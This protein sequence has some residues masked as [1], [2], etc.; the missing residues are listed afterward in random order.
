MK[1]PW[2][3]P[4]DDVLR[5]LDVNPEEG[6]SA[7]AVKKR[8]E[9]Y[10]TNRLR[11]AR[12][13]GWLDI[14]WGQI[15][16]LIV[17]LLAVASIVAFA[18]G[19]FIEG[20][21]I[22]VVIVLNT[23]IG[24]FTELRAVKSMEALRELGGVE[25]FVFREGE[26]REMSADDLVPGD[27]VKLQQGDLVTADIRLI[28][29]N[30]LQANE[31]GL[32]GESVAVEKT[33]E[34]VD[35][36]TPLAE[37]ESMVYKGTAITRGEAMGVVVRTGMETE[38]GEITELVDEAESEQTP[39]ERRLETLGNKLIFLTLA[40]ASLVTI[41]GTLAG[42]EL[43]R[44]IETG[45][46]LAV[47]AVPE[48]LPIV[49]TIAL[50]RGM[51]R[52]AEKNA[53]INRLSAVETLGSTTTIFTD[54]T[55]TLTENQM[56]VRSLHSPSSSR[57]R[58]VKE[59]EHLREQEGE[60]GSDLQR[61]LHIGM[62]CNNASRVETEEGTEEMRG[63]PM[64]TALLTAGREMGIR[65][66]E[67]LDRHPEVREEAFSSET[68][69]MATFHERKE[70]N[71]YYVAVKGA[72]E[73]VLE[74]SDRIEVDGEERDLDPSEVEDWLEQN[75]DLASNG[76][77]LLAMADRTADNPEEDPY[78]NLVFRGLIGFLDPPRTDVREAI[79]KAKR[80]GIKVIMVTGDQAETAANIAREVGI[81]TEGHAEV[82]SGADL[83]N[84]DSMSEE[85]KRSLLDI[86]VY[87]RVSPGQKLTLVGLHQ[88]YGGIA[89]MTGDGV[90]DAPAL[91]KA[92]IGISMG[93]R[94]TQ[95]AR[96]ASDM[97]LTDD[98]FSTIVTA[99]EEG[100]IIFENIRKFVFYLLSCN[101]SE[102]FVVGIAS[103][104]SI[105]LPILPLQILFLNLVTDVFPALALGMGEGDKSIMNRPPR[106]PEEP[107]LANRHWWG[108]GLYGIVFTVSVLGAL[109]GASYLLDLPMEEEGTVVTISFL[110]LAFSQLW[111][112]FN[113]REYGSGLISNDITRNTYVWGAIVLCVSLLLAVTYI[114]FLAD[115]LHIQP[116]GLAGWGMIIGMSLLPLIYGQIVKSLEF[117]LPPFLT[118][119]SDRS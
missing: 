68:N 74:A 39:L 87:S 43:Y 81:V 50:A 71:D 112:V 15:K 27:I 19:E 119:W 67:L 51:W 21:A 61:L 91:K 86:P 16:S 101:V 9:K 7:S 47:A 105:P 115:V 33:V 100:R 22:L 6:L 36:D 82:R 3:E 94:G 44:M 60:P 52:M 49:A 102:I 35:E 17:G 1:T 4:A 42:R 65:R 32:T 80:A 18:F 92:D 116:P 85:E 54:K 95:V 89:G 37:R 63:D 11:E 90:N 40:I 57:T 107:V 10:G 46:A 55:G 84:V 56:S 45:I 99:I 62:L 38:L 75:R 103:I 25:A 79:R 31:S 23:I 2:S 41:S 29:E 12:T 14:L 93:Q 64:E 48:G 66:R 78:Q 59:Q 28:E 97:V 118:G 113:M 104:L 98:A 72:P 83:E 110:T 88:K 58:D 24:F 26:M 34:P 73:S 96:E 111:H 69:M 8:R 13:R 109:F 76:L 106:D 117:H 108:I 20:A 53:L 30:N 114:P 5:E 77:R 70:G